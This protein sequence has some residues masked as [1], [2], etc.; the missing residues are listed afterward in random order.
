MCVG[1]GGGG[2]IGGMVDKPQ[3]E[4]NKCYSFCCFQEHSKARSEAKWLLC[5]AQRSQQ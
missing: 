2:E 1:G 3:R 4:R 5:F